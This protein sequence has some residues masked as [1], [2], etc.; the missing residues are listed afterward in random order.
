MFEIDAKINEL[1]DLLDSFVSQVGSINSHD[2]ENFRRLKE[3]AVEIKE[4]VDGKDFPMAGKVAQSLYD[5]CEK[6]GCENKRD[7]EII[8]VHVNALHTIFTRDIH[9]DGGEVGQEIL[10]NLEVLTG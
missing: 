2:S 8:K 7:L 3:T 10:K 1:R 6:N 5:F 9:D 4:N